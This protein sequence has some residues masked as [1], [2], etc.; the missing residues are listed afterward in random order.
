MGALHRVVDA[1]RPGDGAPL[2][3]RDRAS[4]VTDGVGLD[5]ALGG[6]P[7]DGPLREVG[8]QVVE[9]VDVAP[10]GVGID[11]ALGEEH[12][13]HP[14]EEGDVPTGPHGEVGVRDHRRLR[15][16]GIDDDDAGRAALA[17]DPGHQQRVVVGHVG[18][19]QDEDVGQRQVVVAPGRAVG[20]EA[21]LV[22]RHGRR[23]AQRGVA[24]VVGEAHAQPDELAQRVELLGHELAGRQHGHRLGAVALEQVVEA[25]R[26]PVERLVPG[27][28]AAVDGGHGEAALG[29]QHLVLRQALRAQPTEVDRVVGIALDGHGPAVP[30]ADAHAAADRAVATGGAD[31]AVDGSAGAD[32][33]AHGVVDV[34]VPVAAVVEADPLPDPVEEPAHQR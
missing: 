30:H 3:A 25:G 9:P 7:L 2:G 16:A 21:Q 31:P 32:G 24:V 14:V 20:A 28:R 8:E 26:H 13:Q 10:N 33:P 15:D 11:Q 5:A 19:P 17:H 23:H 29:G 1:H 4:Q 27:R 6:R 18:A 12:R 34:G 22:A